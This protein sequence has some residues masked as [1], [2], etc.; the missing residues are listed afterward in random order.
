MWV[1]AKKHQMSNFHFNQIMFLSFFYRLWSYWLSWTSQWFVSDCQ[2]SSLSRSNWG[3]E[4]NTITDSVFI[5][6]RSRSSQI[7]KRKYHKFNVQGWEV[8]NTP[9]RVFWQKCWSRL[10]WSDRA[11]WRCSGWGPWSWC[12]SWPQI[13]GEGRET[14]HWNTCT[15][16]IFDQVL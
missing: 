4:R 13:S 6:Q 3:P 12:L 11:F 7:Y 14:N 10:R 16:D 5:N 8:W 15:V 1:S 9:C 2:R